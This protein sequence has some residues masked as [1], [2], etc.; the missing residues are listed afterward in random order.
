M[1]LIGQIKLS[2][3]VTTKKIPGWGLG[4]VRVIEQRSKNGHEQILICPDGHEA[5]FWIDLQQIAQFK[6]RMIYT[7]V[8]PSSDTDERT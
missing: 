2:G 1:Q 5:P 3:D 7:E 6:G 8:S 4:P